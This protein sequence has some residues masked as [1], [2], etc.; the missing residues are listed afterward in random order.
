MMNRE[1]ILRELELLPVWQL[2]NPVPEQV[3]AAAPP[4]VEQPA[5]SE[6][7]AVDE[8]VPEKALRQFRLITSDDAQWV[9]MLPQQQSEEAETLLQNML[10][11]VSIKVGQNIMDADMTHLS[12]HASKV[13]VIMGDVDAQAV[14][15]V[16]E[17]L[18]TLR[19][20]THA[21]QN[22]PVVVTYTP[23]YLLA[24]WQDKAKAWEDL[25]LANFTIANL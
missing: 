15:D 23:E 16:T 4:I 11:A 9:F 12:Q 2:R 18:E 17:P 21:H 3:E 13:I 25:C 24:H 22:T 10:K 19:G 8:G 5:V 14:L 20:E 7:A 6:E 1:D